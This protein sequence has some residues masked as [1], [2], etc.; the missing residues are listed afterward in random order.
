[1]P[2]TLDKSGLTSVTRPPRRYFR[3][4]ERALRDMGGEEE[5]YSQATVQRRELVVGGRKFPQL[6][7]SN[8]IRNDRA[9]LMALKTPRA[10]PERHSLPFRVDVVCR[11]C[12]ELGRG[13][14]RSGKGG[15]PII[16][17]ISEELR[18]IPNL[19]PAYRGHSLILSAHHDDL[20]NRV[21]PVKSEKETVLLP[22]AEKTRGRL[23]VRSQ[24]AKVFLY[25]YQNSFWA[26]RN[27]PGS[28]MTFPLHDHWHAHSQTAEVVDYFYDLDPR[29][30]TSSRKKSFR[31]EN[32]P[33]EM[34]VICGEDS[35]PALAS[36][37]TALYNI[38]EKQNIVTSMLFLPF[39]GGSVI[40]SVLD[41]NAP[42][43]NLH[44][45]VGGSVFFNYL[46]ETQCNGG[47]KCPAPRGTV[48][49]ASLT[50]NMIRLS[51]ERH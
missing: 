38:L 45:S 22:A 47:S 2:L 14:L 10:L 25:S 4:W 30:L 24:V 33:S 5:F 48:N 32:S 23:L 51:I 26:N 44:S 31:I 12:R 34:L 36:K 43:Q 27:H 11:L 13:H 8:P 17:K 41:P 49:W 1:M 6:R 20:T 35:L 29:L 46:S 39:R 28:G 21:L 37:A 15:L 3:R 42:S 40:F 19:Y 9:R 7:F 16:T 50:G 18:V